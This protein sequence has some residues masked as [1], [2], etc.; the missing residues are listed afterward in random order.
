VLLTQVSGVCLLSMVRPQRTLPFHLDA[1]I[2]N[3]IAV[4]TREM[5]GTMLDWADFRTV[6]EQIRLHENNAKQ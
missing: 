1:K 5:L 4:F 3:Q 2:P 6:G